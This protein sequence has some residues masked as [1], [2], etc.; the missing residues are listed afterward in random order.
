MN[1][2]ILAIQSQGDDAG[3]WPEQVRAGGGG[4]L[5]LQCVPRIKAAGGTYVHYRCISHLVLLNP[6]LRGL[7]T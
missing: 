5:N 2:A 1:V 4:W 3:A 7:G 6:P